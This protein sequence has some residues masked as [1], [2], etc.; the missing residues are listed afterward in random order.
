MGRGGHPPLMGKG[1]PWRTGPKLGLREDPVG[2]TQTPVLQLST[3]QALR[4]PQVCSST[5]L[6]LVPF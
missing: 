6:H 1:P 5:I 4:L 2:E 3:K